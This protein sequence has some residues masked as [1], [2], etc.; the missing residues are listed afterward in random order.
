L[1]IKIHH[2]AKEYYKSLPVKSQR[3]IKEHVDRLNHYPDIEA[4][5][6]CIRRSPDSQ[7]WRMHISRTVTLVYTVIPAE[8]QIHVDA[9]MTI[10]QAHKKYG[11]FL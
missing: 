3:I 7:L 6:E 9:L 10:E 5:V 8:N 11:S 1:L 2:K 4:D